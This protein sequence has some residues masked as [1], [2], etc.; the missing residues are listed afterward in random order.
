MDWS[1]KVTATLESL[2]LYARRRGLIEDVDLPYY[3]NLLLD[4]MGLDAPAAV[5][6]HDL[7][8]ETATTLLNQLTALARQSRGSNP[9]FL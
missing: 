4:V 7:G 6:A 1:E 3:R 9:A 5:E 2:L 8:E